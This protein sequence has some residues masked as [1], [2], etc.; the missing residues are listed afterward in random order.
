MT[1][2]LIIHFGSPRNVSE[3]RPFLERIFKDNMPG[4]LAIPISLLAMR[5]SLKKYK[6]AGFGAAARMDALAGKIGGN[7]FAA[8]Q[9][10]TP[11]I[12]DVLEK[13]DSAGF[14]RVHIVPLY[15]HASIDMYDSIAGTIYRLK[16]EHYR[17]MTFTWA[18]PF[19]DHP[20]FIAAWGDSVKSA[21][22][23]FERKETVH[24][25]YCAHAHPDDDADYRRQV[26]RTA[27]LISGGIASS[28]AVSVAFQSAA[29][30]GKWSRPSLDEKILD[31][32][33]NG[34]KSVLIAPVSFLFDNVETLFDIG[35]K[36]IP[37]ALGAGIREVRYAPP[38]GDSM[39][40]AEML[41]SII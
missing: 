22:K 10:G 20:L 28:N 37:A 13:I 32:A 30:L 40:I 17:N 9:Y 21:L 34:V 19:F 7:V 3:V 31:L 18:G 2:T 25:I 15:P 6:A 26:E 5:G 36:S 12:G 41:R 11:S 24:V 4:V 23:H 27:T 35:T 29:P 8:A 1:A 33:R 38:P 39:K 14:E 16:R